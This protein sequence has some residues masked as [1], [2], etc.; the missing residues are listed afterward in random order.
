[1]NLINHSARD[2]LLRTI[3]GEI[4][5]AENPGR[6]MRKW[7]EQFGV[8]QHDLALQLGISPSVISDYESG[9]RK[10]PRVETIRKFAE[11]LLEI[12]EKRGGHFVRAFLRL[13]GSDIPSD[14]LLDIREFP[15]AILATQLTEFLECKTIVDDEIPNRE[16]FGYTTIDSLKAILQLTPEQML[17]LYG[18]TPNRA[19]IFTHVSTGR[20]PMVAIRTSQM[21]LGSSVRPSIV[22]LHGPTKVDPVATKIAEVEKIPLYLSTIKETDALVKKLRNFNPEV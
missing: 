6:A 18:A 12:D 8:A 22:I 15:T 14:I 11:C 10:S 2:N 21:G 1:M 13:I 9:R 19:A 3:A 5:L 20:S 17:K 4:T 7:R 16:L